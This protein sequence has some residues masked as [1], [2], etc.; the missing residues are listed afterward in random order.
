MPIDS[1]VVTRRF[2]R[3]RPV[4][5]AAARSASRFHRD[6]T[7]QPIEPR[8]T[9]IREVEAAKAGDRE[10]LGSL[11]LRFKDNVYGYV[12]SIVRDEHEAE[13]VTMSVETIGSSL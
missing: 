8:E 6:A 11:Y 2:A 3:P 1:T 7:I 10:A 4:G 9:I 12:C 5:D 13:D